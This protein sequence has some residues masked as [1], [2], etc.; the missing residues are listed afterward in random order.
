MPPVTKLKK[1]SKPECVKVKLVPEEAMIKGCKTTTSSSG[2]G[3]PCTSGP[4]N[5]CSVDVS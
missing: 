4:G 3:V 2:R 5:S 1:W